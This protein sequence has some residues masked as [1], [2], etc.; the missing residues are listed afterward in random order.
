MPD[1]DYYQ[2]LGVARTASDE[3]IRKAFRKQAMEFHPDRNKDPGAEEKFKEINEAYQVLSDSKKRAQYDAY[4]K[5][6][7]NGNNGNDRPFDGFDVFGGFGD[8]FDSFFGG[9]SGQRGSQAQRG[10]D[11]EQRVVLS[12]EEAVFGADRE[13]EVNRLE[14]CRECS[15]AG[16]EPGTA[17]NTCATCRGSGQVRRVQRSVFGQFAQVTSCTTCNGSGKTFENP[18]SNCRASGME[19]RRRKIEVKIP[20]GVEDGMQVRLTGEGD[21]GSRGG[22]NGNLYVRLRVQ[23]HQDFQRDG[24]DLLYLLPLNIAEASLGGE[25]AVPTLDGGD[26]LLKFPAGTQAG[27]E[28]RVRGRGIPHLNANR[29]GDLRVLVDLRVPGKLNAKQRA[30]LEEFARSMDGFDPPADAVTA[31][32]IP[33][34]P[35]PEEAAAGRSNAGPS[36]KRSNGRTNGRSKGRAAKDNAEN[37]GVDDPAE[38]QQND[39]GKAKDTRE[40]GIFGRIKESLG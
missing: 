14:Q 25:K 29:R 6:G 1:R 39:N 2:S 26:H 19:R 23:A 22:P 30:L 16:N 31:D 27:Q 32:P 28:F 17:V 10:D 21:R 18:C 5:A 20:A 36:N 11:L 4:G 3:D 37:A 35:I 38:H 40:K 8:I 15:G 33:A 7:V 9:A 24:N 34:D 12:F 13:V